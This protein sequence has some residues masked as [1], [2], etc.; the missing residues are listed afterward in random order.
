MVFLKWVEW[1]VD[2]QRPTIPGYI[3]DHMSV[4]WVE[5]GVDYKHCW[6]CT[7]SVE[8]IFEFKISFQKWFLFMSSQWTGRRVSIGLLR[9]Q[10]FTLFFQKN[11]ETEEWVEWEVD[12]TDQTIKSLTRYLKSLKKLRRVR[13]TDYTEYNFVSLK[14]V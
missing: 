3:G 2:Y 14:F 7:W 1:D 10:I 6:N 8:Q 5:W 9:Y 13:G 12:L 4:Q 11:Q